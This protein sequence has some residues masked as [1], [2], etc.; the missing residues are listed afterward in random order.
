VNPAA[1]LELDEVLEGV[2]GRY[3]AEPSSLISVLQDLQE[4]LYYLPRESL[5]GVSRELGVPRSQVY[6][7][8]TFFTAFSLERRGKHTISICRGTA[9]H[10]KGADKIA[11]ILH[12]ELKVSEGETTDDGMFT[13]QS[14]RCL[15]CCS[16]AP[17]IMIDRDVYGGVTP[18][19]LKR[20][21]KRY[22]DE[23]S[24]D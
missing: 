18:A 22:R 16:L 24:Q 23:E 15:G 3:P 7:V 4:E 6:H 10:V 14:V 19:S 5:D 13:V 12:A 17:A 21:V 8:A 11:S 1:E 2:L 20:I 9:C